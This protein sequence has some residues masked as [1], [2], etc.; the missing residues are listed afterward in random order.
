MLQQAGCEL[1]SVDLQDLISLAKM[2]ASCP[3]S[4][5]ST[6]SWE[7]RAFTALLEQLGILPQLAEMYMD[8]C[9]DEGNCDEDFILFFWALAPFVSADLTEHAL[10]GV[11]HAFM[12]PMGPAIALSVLR[13]VG[14][15]PERYMTVRGRLGALVLTCFTEL[16]R[17]ESDY[18]VAFA[19]TLPNSADEWDE[20]DLDPRAVASAFWCDGDEPGLAF[21]T[22]PFALTRRL[23]ASG[24]SRLQTLSGLCIDE[25]I[26]RSD[27]CGEILPAPLAVNRGQVGASVLIDVF[28]ALEG[29]TCE[30]RCMA[31]EGLLV[32]LA[33][34]LCRDM[35]S[36]EL[37]GLPFECDVGSAFS[38]IALLAADAN[39]AERWSGLIA[40]IRQY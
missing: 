8:E 4:D 14:C 2:L 23:A 6:G 3:E 9:C 16:I 10:E 19:A 12:L 40:E 28:A 32:W 39:S 21:G 22:N 18:M 1:S 31:A 29:S 26:S 30:V 20:C 34:V 37:A 24:D 35:L 15:C 7:V 11:A 33:R 5:W 27:E 17:T 25:I 13:M 38:T 36:V